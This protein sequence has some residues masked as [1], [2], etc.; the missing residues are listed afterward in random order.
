MSSLRIKLQLQLSV[1]IDHVTL[2]L[3]SIPIRVNRPR[4]TVVEQL[5]LSVVIDHVTL[6]LDSI[7]IRGNRPRYTVAGQCSY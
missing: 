1:V 7:P 3:D 5:Q 2:L 6:L 4:Y